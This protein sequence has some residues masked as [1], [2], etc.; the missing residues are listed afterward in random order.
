MQPTAV[1]IRKT[2]TGYVGAVQFERE[3]PTLKQAADFAYDAA[4]WGKKSK[5][6]DRAVSADRG[7]RLPL[8]Q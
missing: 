6:R 2:R 3:F 7:D 8:H 1:R 4:N 5:P